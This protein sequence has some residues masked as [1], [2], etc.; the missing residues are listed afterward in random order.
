MSW[1][2]EWVGGILNWLLGV[3]PIE[4]PAETALRAFLLGDTD[5]AALVVD[6]VYPLRNPQKATPPW[7]VLTLVSDIRDPHLRGIQ[8]QAKARYQVDCWA[9]TYDGAVTLGALC[10]RRLS[11][12]QGTLTLQTSPAQAVSVTIF[13]ENQMVIFEE[14]IQGGLCRHSADYFVWHRAA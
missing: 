13:P 2:F 10:A 4:L 3:R 9:Q 5:V 11:G 1:L 8:A 7:I 6:R 12:F 14:D